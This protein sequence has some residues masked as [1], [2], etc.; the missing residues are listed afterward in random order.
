[1]SS[2]VEALARQFGR[3]ID[4]AFEKAR[5][6]SFDYS[7]I[8]FNEIIKK[9]MVWIARLIQWVKGYNSHLRVGLQV[10]GRGVALGAIVKLT[11]LI[12]TWVC[13]FL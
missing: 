1:M 6:P 7:L 12:Q 4:E 10:S 13:R 3:D 11:S 8:G 5:L 9:S 2:R